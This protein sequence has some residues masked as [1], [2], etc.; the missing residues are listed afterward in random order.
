MVSKFVKKNCKSQIFWQFKIVKNHF[1]KI[2]FKVNKFWQLK[3]VTNCETMNSMNKEGLKVIFQKFDGLIKTKKIDIIRK[4][5]FYDAN[6]MS[7][8]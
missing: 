7:V 2:E 3:N 8:D 4:M 5:I 6:L 1:Y